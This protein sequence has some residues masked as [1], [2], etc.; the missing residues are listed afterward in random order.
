[1]VFL[2][3]HRKHHAQHVVDATPRGR[4]ELLLLVAL[5]DLQGRDEHS[6]ATLR[7]TNTSHVKL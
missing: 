7:E 3:R 4:A 5:H 6:A 2:T 1:M